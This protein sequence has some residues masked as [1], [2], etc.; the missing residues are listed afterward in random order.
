MNPSFLCCNMLMHSPMS[1]GSLHNQWKLKT[2]QS[3]LTKLLSHGSQ[4]L[5]RRQLDL[6]LCA[7]FVHI[8]TPTQRLKDW[9]PP[10]VNYEE[11]SWMRGPQGTQTTPVAYDTALRETQ[12]MHITSWPCLGCSGPACSTGCS[13]SCQ[14][15]F[16]RPQS[17]AWLTLSLRQ[18]MVTDPYL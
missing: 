15:T 14:P 13:D 16:N 2:T 1:R 11:A 18:M 3:L 5:Y 17:R 8:P 10:P 4:V 9:N 6:N 7:Y 12:N